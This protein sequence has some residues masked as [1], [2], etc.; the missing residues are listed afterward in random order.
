MLEVQERVP[1]GLRQW[2]IEKQL[3]A[4]AD[5]NAQ[6]HRGVSENN[7]L[8]EHLGNALISTYFN[9]MHP[10]APILVEAEVKRTWE[11]LWSPPQRQTLC[12]N[13]E[14][15]ILYMV[16]A[17][18]ARLHDPGGD[19]MLMEWAEHFYA[20]AGN[21]IDIFE[22]TTLVGTHLM[23]LRAIYAMQIGKANWIYL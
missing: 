12:A 11:S 1:E 7:Y 13:K 21:F 15:S 2:G 23:L 5:E 19:G 8:P 6:L 18:G 10:Q 22:E 14:R 9:V 3:F 20:C 4:R 16:F 17:I